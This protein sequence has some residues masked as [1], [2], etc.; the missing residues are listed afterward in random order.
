MPDQGYTG[1]N[2]D[3]PYSEYKKKL[4]SYKVDESIYMFGC[5]KFTNEHLKNSEGYATKICNIVVS[6]LS[7]LKEQNNSSYKE[8][9]CKYLYYWLHD[10]ISGNKTLE[11]TLVV[12]KA[13]NDIFNDQNDGLNMFDNYI[14]QMN[15]DIY[16]KI[17]K[18][19]LIYDE[20]NKFEKQ[21]MPPSSQK[22]CSSECVTLFTSCVS[23]CR[24]EYDY[25]FCSKLKKF[26]DHYNYFIQTILKC[27]GDQYLL[28]PVD[29]L[30]IVKMIIVPFVL[31]LVACFIL[32]LLYK[33]TPVG[34]WARHIIGKKK[35]TW[36]NI[37]QEENHLL[38]DYEMEK[39][40]PKKMHYKLA[41][42]SS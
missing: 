30:D 16:H 22:K 20:F 24:K 4:D 7:H 39:D 28:P 17:K 27:K 36:D 1:N 41:Y 14:N 38:D 34:P 18:I 11:D 2:I 42:N 12:Y 10:E 31:L 25:D 8:N 6:L 19:I 9:G 32:P 23:E 5:D 15:N 37:S 13:L 35:N 40:F 26:R 3:N 29:N 33:F 21:V